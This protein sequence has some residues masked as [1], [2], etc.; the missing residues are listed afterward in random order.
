M[1]LYVHLLMLHK[2]NIGKIKRVVKEIIKIEDEGIFLSDRS[3]ELARIMLKY[4]VLCAAASPCFIFSVLGNDWS[5]MAGS[6]GCCAP[7]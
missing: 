4:L 2:H 1:V 6:L 5:Q 3:S 7:A